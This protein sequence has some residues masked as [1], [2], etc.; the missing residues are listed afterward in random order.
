MPSHLSVEAQT[1]KKKK[2][3]Q[4]LPGIQEKRSRNRLK[5]RKPDTTGN[6]ARNVGN[7]KLTS[8]VVTAN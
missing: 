2:I 4:E 8:N 1:G 5:I 3:P 7:W 6:R